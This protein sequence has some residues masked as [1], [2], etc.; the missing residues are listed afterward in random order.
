MKLWPRLWMAAL[1]PVVAFGCT[2]DGSELP[3][4]LAGEEGSGAPRS[5]LLI[6]VDTTRAD[7]LE[8]YGA[9]DVETPTLAQLAAEGVTFEKASAVAPVTLVA[10]T[11]IMTGR[12]P[13]EHGV[14]NNGIH[15]VPP[16][17]DTL[18][19]R[20]RREGYR[21]A[22]FVSA[23][24]LER[25]YGLDQGFELY[26][27]DLSQGRGR[28]PRMVPDR[29]AEVTVASAKA[30]LDT[31]GSGE[32]FFAWVHFY[33]PHA[34]YSPPPPYRDK[35]RARLYDG[36]I[37]YMDAQIGDLLEHPAV[38]GSSEED[39][40]VVTL[41]GDHGESLGEHGE[42]THAILAYE[43]TLHVPWLLRVPGGPSGVRI[44]R[45]VSQVDLAPTLLSLVGL[46][47]DPAHV[48][49][50]L[51]QAIHGNEPKREETILYSESYLP[52]YTYGWSKLHAMRLGRWK[53][54]DAPTPEL[55]DLRRDPRELT[56]VHDSQPGITHDLRRALDEHLAR[57]AETES[58]TALSL[59]DEALQNLQALGYMAVGSGQIRV[60]G[61]RGDPKELIRLHVLLERT[62]QFLQD[63][64]YEQAEQQ[65][66]L[67]LEQ[68]PSNLAAQLELASALEGQ[69]R[70]DETV[71][72]LTRALELDPDYTRLYVILSRV[73][74][75]R[76]RHDQALELAEIAT[77][78]DPRN[79]DA[80]MQ[81]VNV[82]LRLDRR[83]QAEA[84]L[85]SAL[86]AQPESPKLNVFYAQNFELPEG[87]LDDAEARLRAAL[88]RDP[89]R[90]MGWYTLGQALDRSGREQEALES[91]RQGLQRRADDVGLHAAL[92]QLLARLGQLDEAEPHLEEAIRLSNTFRAPLYVSLGALKAEK[93]QYADAEALYRRVLEVAP[94]D[95]AARNNLAITLYRTGRRD[96][97]EGMLRGIIADFPNMADAHN[98]L[99]AL[100]VDGNDWKTGAIHAGRAVELN[101][102]FVE[103]WNNLGIAH[104][105][106]GR[107]LQALEAYRRA[108]EENP[109]YWQAR[110][111]LGVLQRKEGDYEAAAASFEEVLS[112]VPTLADCHFELAELYAGELDKPERARTHYNAFLRHAP[113]D[114]RAN[115]IRQRVAGLTAGR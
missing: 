68:D 82:L 30:W 15:Y 90:V 5:I 89:Y 102:H 99:A 44:K 100:A 38:R 92:G 12:Y 43:S 80:L 76:G 74:V 13:S 35:Y 78:Q 20:L 39:A 6:T 106:Q 34:R 54:I 31:L 96:E 37:S 56:N 53:Y 94:K 93:G 115:E 17:V 63:H 19:E 47:P 42:Q 45:P 24:V 46:A 72:A 103:A 107:F 110:F 62:R 55:Y 58:E 91:Y 29:P 26:D 14:H 109:D 86:R 108:L 41:I 98:N 84:L 16:G 61:E 3:T 48:G 114:P 1:T 75:R 23:A 97:A 113:A 73:E 10:H 2:R 7:H 66:Q 69:G 95:G 21:T 27:D 79:P 4:V 50:D 85:E 11:S 81:K 88:D 18:A 71:E 111:N 28:A 8:P 112:R 101:P 67:V 33:D 9:T 40:A 64:L 49:R 32:R 105:E 77:D 57:S 22:A 52:Y 70:L 87:R 104:E 51:S 65:I 36:E 59:D 83:P 25:R 60:E